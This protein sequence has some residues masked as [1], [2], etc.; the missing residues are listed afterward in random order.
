MKMSKEIAKIPMFIDLAGG[1]DGDRI[2]V[3][4]SQ[5]KLKRIMKI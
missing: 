4:R 5:K 2:M 1:D 3:Y